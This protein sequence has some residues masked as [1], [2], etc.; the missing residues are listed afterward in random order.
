MTRQRL[1]LREGDLA[2][3]AGALGTDGDTLRDDLERRPWVD[4]DVL[5]RAEVVDTVLNGSGP[6]QLAVSPMLFFAVLTHRAADELLGSDWVNEWAGPGYRL[7]VFD[8]EPLL[9]FADAPE[10]LLFTARLLASFAG[11]GDAP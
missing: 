7:P 6:E 5:R 10:R 4:N 11:P 3:L 8:V 2:L 1:N 9:E